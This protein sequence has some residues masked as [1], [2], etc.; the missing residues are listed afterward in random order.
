MDFQSDTMRK[1]KKEVTRRREE[2]SK[3]GRK[4]GRKEGSKSLGAHFYYLM[5][6]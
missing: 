2:V 6:S 5:L 1:D 4:G 3:E